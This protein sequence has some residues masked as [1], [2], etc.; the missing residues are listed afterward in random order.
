MAKKKA[1]AKVDAVV[2]PFDSGV[3]YAQF[4]KAL[5]EGMKPSE[6]LKDVCSEEQLNWLEIELKH[7]KEKK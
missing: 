2:N 4:V 3:T 1:V 5:P 7:F 6:Y